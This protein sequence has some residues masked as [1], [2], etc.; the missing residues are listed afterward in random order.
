MRTK[1]AWRSPR[2]SRPHPCRRRTAADGRGSDETT[3]SKRYGTASG[4]SNYGFATL[5]ARG[6]SPSSRMVRPGKQHARRA[7]SKAR[8][9]QAAVRG[10]APD[11][12]W[13]VDCFQ[14][15]LTRLDRELD[16]AIAKNHAKNRSGDVEEWLSRLD[17]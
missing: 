13:T 10:V 6:E 12:A 1:R 8:R 17:L 4:V 9:P 7:S 2:S 14:A 5:T 15:A 16:G 11:A 3:R